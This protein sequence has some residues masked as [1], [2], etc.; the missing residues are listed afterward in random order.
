MNTLRQIRQIVYR[1]KREFGTPAT[2]IKLYINDLDIQTGVVS[3]SVVEYPISRV[4]ILPRVVVREFLSKGNLAD[5]S[6]TT[7]LI[8]RRDISVD[9]TATDRIRI[10][11]DEYAIAPIQTD[12]EDENY[13]LELKRMT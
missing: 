1:L 12:L 4:V 8:D 7:C 10:R 9:I 5:E 6:K 3:R 13:L 2:L 11:G